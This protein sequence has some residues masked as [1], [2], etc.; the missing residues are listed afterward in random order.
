V[1]VSRFD[2]LAAMLQIGGTMKYRAISIV[3]AATITMSVA[4][5]EE[6]SP[7]A[8]ATVKP[9]EAV[10]FDR[11]SIRDHGP[12]RSFEI[13]IVWGDSGAPR[14]VGHLSRRV[15]YVANCPAGTLGVVSVAVYGSDGMLQKSMIS[16]P[17]ATDPVT[18]AA[19][20]AQARWLRDVCASS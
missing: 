3:L 4:A 7:E 11:D 20:S 17:G 5:Q 10:R 14:P 6:S 13:A 12:S 8:M 2:S 9:G 15:R 19:D 1:R 16:P 18:P